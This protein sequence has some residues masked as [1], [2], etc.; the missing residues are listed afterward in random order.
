MRILGTGEFMAKEKQKTPGG[1]IAGVPKKE[2]PGHSTKETP[3]ITGNRTTMERRIG[4]GN[5][6]RGAAGARKAAD[7]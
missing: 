4:S 3:G 2:N 6:R 7:A 5:T 1:K